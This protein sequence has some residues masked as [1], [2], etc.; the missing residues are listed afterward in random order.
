MFIF[1]DN[2]NMGEGARVF[3]LHVFETNAEN[4]QGVRKLLENPIHPN[5]PKGLSWFSSG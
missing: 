3:W 4:I 1:L 2:C 5:N